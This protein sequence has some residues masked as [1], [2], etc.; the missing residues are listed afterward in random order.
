LAVCWGSNENVDRSMLHWTSNMSVPAV[1]W[2]RF[3]GTRLMLIL[4]GHSQLSRPMH[5]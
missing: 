1:H 3:M 2:Q 4:A 5:M